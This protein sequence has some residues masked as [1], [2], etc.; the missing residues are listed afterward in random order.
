MFGAG[1]GSY[2]D[3]MNYIIENVSGFGTCRVFDTIHSKYQ[4]TCFATD[5]TV[6]KAPRLNQA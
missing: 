5:R 4:A 3:L 6:A 2:L 1:G